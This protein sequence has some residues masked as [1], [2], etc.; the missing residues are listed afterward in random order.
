MAPP[1]AG[2]AVAGRGWPWLQ[3]MTLNGS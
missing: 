3:K 1:S 2:L